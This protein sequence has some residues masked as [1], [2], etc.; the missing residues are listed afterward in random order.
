MDKK[1]I[2]AIVLIAV[3][4]L[5]LPYYQ[6]LITGDQPQKPTVVEKSKPA[7]ADTINKKEKKPITAYKSITEEKTQPEQEEKKATKATEFSSSLEVV[8]DSVESFIEIEN[9]NI[10][11]IISNRGGG[12]IKEYVLKQY[13]KYDSSLVNMVDEKINNDLYIGFQNPAGEY[14]NPEKYLFYSNSKINKKYLKPGEVFKIE[15]SIKIS[16]EELKKTI[17]FYDDS[18]HFDVVVNFSNPNQMLL[19]SRYQFGWQNGLPSTESYEEDD[20]NYNQVYFYMGDELEG[21]SVDDPGKQETINLSG[22]ADWFAVRTKYFITA[23]SNINADVDEG[24]YYSGEGIKRAEYVQRIYDVGYHIYDQGNTGGDSIRVY[25]GPLDHRELG[26]YENNLD[27][28]IMNNGWYE[29][30]FRFFSMLVLDVLELL[31]KVIPNW[32]IVIIVFS[33]LIKLVVYP[34]T[35][36]SYQ[37]MKEMQKIQPL[38]TEMKEKYKGD[39]QRLNKETMK[40]YKEHGVN[41]LGGCLPMLLQ[42]PLLIALFIVFRS[43][44]QLR[45]AT[46]IPGWIDDLSRM[47]TLFVLPFSLPMY[48]DHFNLLPILMAVTMMFQ[49]KMTMQDPKQK[50]MVYL[51]PVFMLLIF[52]RFPSGLNLYYTLFNLLTIVQQKFVHTDTK[53]KDDGSGKI[54]KKK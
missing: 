12:S 43:T 15:Y 33:I 38:M 46:F 41:P 20:N 34:L 3:I 26:K 37:S 50:A 28:L 30:V 19:N 23:L 10:R 8:Q 25:I 45:G 7:H 2:I 40:L 21:Y 44:I 29:R 47:D 31:H 54:K 32:G 51:M 11:I 42:M 48:G 16:D 9:D 35:K 18:Y 6:E 22:R 52:N 1:S 39:P 49:S 27:E 14:I 4:I 36:K 13:S 24:I 53:I 5:L 17:I